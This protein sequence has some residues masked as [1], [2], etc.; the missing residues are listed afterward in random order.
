M[1]PNIM[2]FVE[3]IGPEQDVKIK[4][5]GYTYTFK[6]NPLF[7]GKRVEFIRLGFAQSLIS[8]KKDR[9][10]LFDPMNAKDGDETFKSY[11]LSRREEVEKWLSEEVPATEDVTPELI[12]YAS[13]TNAVLMGLCEERGLKTYGAKQTLIDRL[14]ENDKEK[15]AE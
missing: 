13:M 6:P 11:V 1:L 10:Q 8:G 5:S 3:Y 9:L 15:P 14:E 2:G 4:Y 7:C 12:G